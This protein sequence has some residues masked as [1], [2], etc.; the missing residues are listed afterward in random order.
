MLCDVWQVMPAPC[1]VCLLLGAAQPNSVAQGI[2]KPGGRGVSPHPHYF[3]RLGT[4]T[5]LSQE[6]GTWTSVL[7]PLDMRDIS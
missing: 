1:P 4:K 7:T 6:P 2:N 3:S 5:K